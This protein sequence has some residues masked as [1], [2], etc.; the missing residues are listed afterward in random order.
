V[1]R[2]L[3]GRIRP[4]TLVL[5]LQNGIGNVETLHEFLLPKQVLAGRVITGVEIKPGK[6]KI[7]VSAD[8][9]R[10]GETTLKRI[11]GRVKT[12]ARIFSEAGLPTRAVP[13][14]E[15]YLW[16]KLAY[17][18]ALNP[19]AS[20]LKVHYGALAESESTRL[21][22]E[23]MIREV[24]GVAKKKKVKLDPST[25]E[26]YIRLF[27]QKLVPRTYAHHPSMLYDLRQGKRTEID[28]LNG[29]VVRLG[30]SLRVPTPFNQLL[31]EL[32]KNRYH[33]LAGQV[34]P[35]WSL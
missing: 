31:T 28:A 26:G 13:D 11:T 14:V 17:N 27:Y 5:S 4:E 23:E 33:F 20:L 12:I 6:I 10:I 25:A 24:Y 34:S 15:K 19:L 22:M 29:A 3:R 9:T 21:L 1:A 7:T 32:I 8:L 35:D 18:S 30:Q 2:F 16:A